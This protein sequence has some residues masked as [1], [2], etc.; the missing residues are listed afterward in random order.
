MDQRIIPM[1][2]YENG[3]EAMNWLCRVFGFIEKT[4]WLDDA[5]RLSH[6]EITMGESMIM[7]AEPTPHYQSPKH[8]REA[9]KA[10]AKWHQVPYIIN[11]VLVYV[12]NVESHFKTAKAGGAIILSEI[13]A[14]V[15][16]TRYRAEDLEGQRWMFMQKS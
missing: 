10:A 11:G 6:G 1:L 15:P 3:F 7:L 13:E 9:C 8:H 5:G 4:K 14:G 2:S 16:G 12:D